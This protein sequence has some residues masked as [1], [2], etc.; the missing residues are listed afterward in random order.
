MMPDSEHT[1]G[2]TKRSG[3]VSGFSAVVSREVLRGTELKTE[4]CEMPHPPPFQ[5]R[6]GGGHPST[7]RV[8]LNG[9]LAVWWCSD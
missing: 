4:G 9:D 3:Y 5:V 8:G 2:S 1:L 7:L 6:R